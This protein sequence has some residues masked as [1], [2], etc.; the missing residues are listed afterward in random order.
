MKKILA[1]IL[2]LFVTLSV[3]VYKK[4]QRQNEKLQADRVR[5][6]LVANKRLADKNANI[7]QAYE[8]VLQEEG[9]PY[10]LMDTL[11]F[12][13][14]EDKQL[15]KNI[16]A[17]IFP[18]SVAANLSENISAVVDRYLKQG[19]KVL[20]VYDA[21]SVNYKGIYLP[22][23]I[24]KQ[25][26]GF[27]YI[28]QDKNLKKEFFHGYFSF[29]N[30]EERDFWQIPIG[31]TIDK[32]YLSG[33]H[34]GKLT[35]PMRNITQE[36]NL[37]QDD[38]CA[39]AEHEDGTKEPG[40]VHKKIGEG[41]IVYVN[42]PLGALKTQAD[43]LPLR[44][45]LRTFLFSI[46]HVPHVLN[47]PKG[48]GGIVM[49]WHIDYEEELTN[50]PLLFAQGFLRKDI[51][52]SYHITAGPDCDK[53]GDEQG[54]NVEQSPGKEIARELMQYGNIGSHGGWAHN[55][56]ADNLEQGK[57]SD[58]QEEK[59][60]KM[61][62]AAVE[63][64]TGKKV[65]EYS[66]PN[67]VFPQDASSKIMDKNG[68]E[69]YY[70]TGDS[71]SSINRTFYQGKMVSDKVLAFPIVPSG[72]YAS[73][74]EM[75]NYGHYSDE[76]IFNMMKDLLD[77]GCK[78]R[79]VRL[80]YSHPH[81]LPDNGATKDVLDFLDYL[82][83]Q[84]KAKKGQALTMTD[85]AR[86]FHK[87]LLT[88]ATY[89]WDKGLDVAVT[90]PRNLRDICLAVP[91]AGLGMPSDEIITVDQDENFY[92]VTIGDYSEKEIVLHFPPLSASNNA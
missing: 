90:N 63:A 15:K 74:F 88:K 8:S 82:E 68:I 62:N 4:N 23:S 9:V 25:F 39:W 50:L 27:E 12:E 16:P 70:Y 33:Y 61:N 10:E 41:E 76:Q 56:F 18:D 5:V 55:W 92:Y 79:T 2:M 58:E 73:I 71:G 24:F 51:P 60:I 44:A 7:L 14:L 3:F 57:F 45:I 53:V 59:Y 47:V 75:R 87:A 22:Q 85:T 67:G 65:T 32:V 30:P 26:L 43:D 46:A 38:V 66:A 64:S 1:I 83:E 21:G 42:M 37:R 69:V 35:Y 86:F 13:R 49:N 31:K 52:T 89:R 28:P 11:L 91:K 6:I 34:Y 20:T 36:K 54:F 80:F 48:L 17:V 72:K 84:I 77:Y 40:L 78:N 29:K 81:D 19:G